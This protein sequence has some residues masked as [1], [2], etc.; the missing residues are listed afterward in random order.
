[1]KPHKVKVNMITEENRYRFN[2][3]TDTPVFLKNIQITVLVCR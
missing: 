2:P 1:M 3:R